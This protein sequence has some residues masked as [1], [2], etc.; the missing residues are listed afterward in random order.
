MLTLVVTLLLASGCVGRLGQPDA[1]EREAASGAAA[2]SSTAASPSASPTPAA[3]FGEAPAACG[4]PDGTALEYAGRST[5][6]ALGVQEVPGDPMSDDP[7]DVYVTRD[8]FDQG[9]LHGRLVCAIFVEQPDFVEV[10]VHPDD[11][12]PPTPE[13][14]APEPSGGIGEAEATEIA[15][16][17]ADADVAWGVAVAV[18]GPVFRVAPYWLDPMRG[19]ALDAETWVWRIFLVS[20]DRGLDVIVDYVDGSIR[21]T[22]ESIVN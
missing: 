1:S 22:A 6:A 3:S 21:A 14:S 17:A 12:P 16:D 10:T 15:L 7:A 9:S 2:S 4:F 13:P 8:A 5:T 18:A 19:P 20:G 11:V